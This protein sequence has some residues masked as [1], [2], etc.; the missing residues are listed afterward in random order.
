MSCVY[1]YVTVAYV[2]I[3]RSFLVTNVCNQG[4]ALCSPC[5]AN[6][7]IFYEFFVL[8][9]YEMYV[10]MLWSRNCFYDGCLAN[11]SRQ[12]LH[13]GTKNI[14]LLVCN[15]TG[16]MKWLQQIHVQISAHRREWFH[17]KSYCINPLK[18]KLKPIYHLLALLWPHPIFHVSRTRVNAIVVALIQ[19]FVVTSILP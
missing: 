2:C 3:P 9:D 16:F 6:Y 13:Q 1:C 5:I 11:T 17:V 12:I 8:M 18:T 14:C 4:K 15:I 7:E 19:Y 10:C